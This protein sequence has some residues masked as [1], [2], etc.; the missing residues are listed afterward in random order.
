PRL[1][2]RARINTHAAF[3]EKLRQFAREK[4]DKMAV[5]RTTLDE[6]PVIPAAMALGAEESY[7]PTYLQK[8][9]SPLSKTLTHLTT[10]IEEALR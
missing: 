8:Y 4:P 5:F 9:S 2:R 10:E 7:S 1:G 3:E 6:T